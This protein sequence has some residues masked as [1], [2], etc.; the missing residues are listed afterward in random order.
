MKNNNFRS[1]LPSPSRRQ[2]VYERL[3]KIVRGKGQDLAYLKLMLG[4]KAFL[5]KEAVK[6]MVM[7]GSTPSCFFDGEVLTTSPDK[8]TIETHKTCQVQENGHIAFFF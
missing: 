2:D 3:E 6:V 8:S 7:F 5:V 1:S 4:R